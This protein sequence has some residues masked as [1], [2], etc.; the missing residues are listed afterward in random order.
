MRSGAHLVHVSTDYVFDGTLQRPYHEWDE[1]NPQSVYGRSKLGGELEVGAGRHGGAHVVGVRRGRQQHGNHGV[2]AA[3]RRRPAAVRGRPARLPDVHR[4]PRPDAPPAGRRAS[5]GRPPRDEPGRGELVRVRPRHRGR[6]RSSPV[7]GR[8]DLDRRPRSAPPGA[9]AP[10]TA[11]STTPRCGWPASRCSGTTASRWPSSS[12]AHRLTSGP[13]SRPGPIRCRVR[14][15]DGIHTSRAGVVPRRR[16]ARP[17]RA[18]SA[19]ALRRASTPASGRPRR[20]PTSRIPGNRFY[21]ALLRG[22]VIEREIDRGSGMSDADRRH[23]IERGIGITNLVPRATAKASELTAAELRDGG[24]AA[25]SSSCASTRRGSW[26]WPGSRHTARR[27]VSGRAAGAPV[28]PVRGR[29][30]L[31][32]AEPER[33]ERPRDDRLAGRR[34]SG[35]GGGCRRDRRLTGPVLRP[36]TQTTNASTDAR[37]RPRPARPAPRAC[38]SRAS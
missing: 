14:C 22:G 32:R 2:A 26:R 7:A 24:G 28:R 8:A 3:R 12:R 6:R 37:P 10:P 23:L 18:R 29:R 19:A 1:P 27:S 34:L 21:P 13:I 20:R 11:C 33:V 30:A 35:T 16:G 17:R 31:D 15:G 5:I 9:R 36:A 4:R 25:P 38:A